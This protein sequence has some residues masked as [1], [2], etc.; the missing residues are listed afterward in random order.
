LDL[1]FQEF[2]YTLDDFPSE[3]NFSLIFSVA[4]GK[5]LDPEEEERLK[6][7]SLSLESIHPDE[8]MIHIHKA[9]IDLLKKL[10]TQFLISERDEALKSGNIPLSVQQAFIQ[11]AISL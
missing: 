3:G 4:S 8:D 11:K 2:R 10:H 7:I 9:C 6:I 1:F 5:T